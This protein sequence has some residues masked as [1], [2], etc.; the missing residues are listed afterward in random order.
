[1]PRCYVLGG[2]GESVLSTTTVPHSVV[3]I[4]LQTLMLGQLGQLR[5]APDGT[6]PG[7]PDGVS[8][9]ATSLV[10]P[11]C[12]LPTF[13]L[14]AQLAV[15]GYATRG[16]PWDWRQ[17]VYA[18]GILLAARIRAEVTLSDP[19]AIVAH[20]AGGLVARAAWTEL[21]LTSEHGLVRRIVTLGTPHWGSY[22]APAYWQGNSLS[23][24]WLIYAN[25][26]LGGPVFGIAPEFWGYTLQTRLWHRQL[27]L[28]W[29]SFY[30]VLPTLGAPDAAADPN[31][32]LL[33]D[34][35][36]W[37][38]EAR[39]QQTWLDHS[40]NVTG[41][42]LRSS[43]SQPPSQVITCISGV[44][45][46]LSS[47]L[48]SP[49][50]FAE[51]G[52]LGAY[53]DG[54]NAVTSASAELSGSVVWRY[55]ITHE[56]LMASLANSGDLANYVLEVREPGPAP[57]PEQSPDPQTTGLGALPFAQ[58]PGLR[59]PAAICAAGGCTC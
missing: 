32:A 33:Y 19:C 48:T 2:L 36:N 6:S 46:S 35:A 49:E 43:A 4:N 51:G 10:A 37:P 20:S 7:P 56:N 3:W 28:T 23:I 41:P 5:L 55:G 12:G 34:A 30:D 25:D 16:H 59:A 53:A 29:P 15:Q 26:V 58:S 27:A 47:Q 18:A 57:N 22:N 17:S 8:C 42:W 54:D 52:G 14:A 9:A 11:Y 1:M 40:K 45:Y 44:G 31:R 21:G 50:Q 39:P 24:D 13:I 38:A